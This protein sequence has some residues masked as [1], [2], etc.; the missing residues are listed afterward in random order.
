MW[1]RR[2]PSLTPL[3]PKS[4]PLHHREHSTLSHVYK[5][6]AL[7]KR[8]HASGQQSEMLVRCSI[9]TAQQLQMPEPHAS[10]RSSS[11]DHHTSEPGVSWPGSPCSHWSAIFCFRYSYSGNW[12]ATWVTPIIVGPRPLRHSI[13]RLSQVW[14]DQ[15]LPDEVCRLAAGHRLCS[16]RTL[17]LRLHNDQA[18]MHA[19]ARRAAGRLW[20]CQCPGVTVAGAPPVRPSSSTLPLTVH[21]SVKCQ[22]HWKTMYLYRPWRPSSLAM[23]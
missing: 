5:L 11:A 16:H 6:V 10:L 15:Q 12:M 21:C 17:N 1:L 18:A 4:A 9:G 2:P 14:R 3:T 8:E 23:R 22:H 7:G 19:A 13:L 20:G